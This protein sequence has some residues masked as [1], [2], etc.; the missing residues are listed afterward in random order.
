MYTLTIRLGRPEVFAN[1]RVI[2]LGLSSTSA[3]I[4]PDILPHAAHP[5][6]SSHRRGAVPF[7]RF[8]KGVPADALVTYR[9]RKLSQQFQAH[10]PNLCRFAADVAVRLYVKF[11]YPDLKPE[12]RLT[13]ITSVT[14][15]VPSALT[16]DDVLPCLRDGSIESVHGIRRFLGPK[17]VELLDGRVLDDIDA[18]VMCTGYEADFGVVGPEALETS[19]PTAHGYDKAPDGPTAMYRLW[20]NIFPPKYADSFAMLCY[21]AFGKSNGFS[22]ADV[23]SMAV[24]N[25]FRGAHPLPPVGEMERWVDEHHA[26]VASRWKLDHTIDTSMVKVWE[27]QGWLH[28]AAGTGLEN[29][30][31]L[32]WKG[33]K[34]WWEDPQMYNLMSNGIETAHMY[35]YFETGK[36]KTWPGAKE[37]ILKVEEERKREL[38]VTPQQEHEYLRIKVD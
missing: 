4:L 21:S 12:W 8:R 30:S 29:L 10:F 5:V 25:V 31:L 32:G 38:P 23:T 11:A 16:F 35:K 28:D 18:V 27:Y 15:K 33:W 36:R 6:Y 22:F 20:M 13:N 1:K 9:R 24:S 3:D 14:L 34:F 7:Q 26:W 17:A 19:V 2:V 37:A